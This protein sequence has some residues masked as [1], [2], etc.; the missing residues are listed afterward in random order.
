MDGTGGHETLKD[1]K[2][3]VVREGKKTSEDR[4]TRKSNF[5]GGDPAQTERDS[6]CG[7]LC[8]RCC[9]LRSFLWLTQLRVPWKAATA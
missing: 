9:P 7:L 4:I 2:G 5:A 3:S 8:R 1:H 6:Q